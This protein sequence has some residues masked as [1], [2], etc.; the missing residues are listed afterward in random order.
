M[1]KAICL[2][3]AAMASTQQRGRIDPDIGMA[4]LL[5]LTVTVRQQL[6]LLLGARS[7]VTLAAMPIRQL[8]QP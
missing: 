5:L 4:L 6:L 7:S 8:A 3:P 2:T 1:M